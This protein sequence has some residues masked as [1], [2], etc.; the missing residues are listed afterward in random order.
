[1]NP[2]NKLA[3]CLA[4][5]TAILVIVVVLVTVFASDSE[6]WRVGYSN[7]LVIISV[8]IDTHAKYMTLLFLVA[9]VNI[10][11]VIVEELGMPVLNFSIYNPD[12]GVITDFTKNELQ[13]Y[14]N[15]MYTVSG[16]RS[17][18]MTLV[19]ISQIDIAVWNLL[20]SEIASIYTIR[21]LLNEKEFPD[22]IEAVQHLVEM[23]IV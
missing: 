10:S 14:A 4:V 8:K 2:R 13:F 11:K 12:K 6:F 5:N 22:T 3:L 19:N 9:I 21:V 7:T 23:D 16:L 20:I 18:F 15:A 1:M 17:V